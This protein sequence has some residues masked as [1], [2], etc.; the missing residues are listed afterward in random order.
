MDVADDLKNDPAARQLADELGQA[1]NRI[2]D[3]LRYRDHLRRSQL[4]SWKGGYADRF[5]N[6]EFP[7]DQNALVAARDQ[8]IKLQSVIRGYLAV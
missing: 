7:R 1:A 5:N 4:V 2:D 6:S 8:F 3:Y